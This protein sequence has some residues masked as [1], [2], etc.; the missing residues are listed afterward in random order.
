MQHYTVNREILGKMAW[1]WLLEEN[2]SQKR[3]L[4]ESAGSPATVYFPV[5]I[6]GMVE[7]TTHRNIYK[8]DS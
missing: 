3:P 8:T 5:P 4:Y 2:H 1:I 7:W 6:H